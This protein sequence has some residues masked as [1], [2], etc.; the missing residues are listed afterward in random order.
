MA[1]KPYKSP[2]ID[3]VY[4]IDDAIA[5]KNSTNLRDIRMV[6]QLI[7]KATEQDI[8]RIFADWIIDENIKN[9]MNVNDLDV[10]KSD[11]QKYERGVDL[12]SLPELETN[13]Q[14]FALI[15]MFLNL[16]ENKFEKRELMNW[17]DLEKIKNIRKD[18]KIIKNESD[19]NKTFWRDFIPKLRNC[20]AHNRYI[21]INNGIYIRGRNK[22]R[23]EA[24]VSYDFFLKLVLFC[25]KY[26]RSPYATPIDTKNVDREKWF[27]AN[28]D[29]IEVYTIM[30]ESKQKNNEGELHK[31]KDVSKRSGIDFQMN[32]NKLTSGQIKFLSEYF[33]THEFN[34]ANLYFIKPFLVNNGIVNVKEIY[35]IF[36][37]YSVN[38][39]ILDSRENIIKLLHP[40]DVVIKDILE[41]LTKWNNIDEWQIWKADEDIYGEIKKQ[42]PNLGEDIQENILERILHYKKIFLERKE[43]ENYTESMVNY[44]VNYIK[45]L[46]L[47]KFYKNN[48]KLLK[49]IDTKKKDDPRW[50]EEHIRN[51]FA[52]HTYAIIP[53]FNKILLQDKFV[54][55]TP[56]WEK[57]YD[58]DE[59]YQ[60][61]V[62]RVDEDYLDIKVAA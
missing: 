32:T 49:L 24:K 33:K 55:G 5:M 53:W 46:Y 45:S 36:W 40:D 48:P 30:W 14:C 25:S 42:N 58:L 39:E 16:R 26:E 19:S 35:A 6:Q 61:A 15:D 31:I 22:K 13:T 28:K 34:R 41:M 11:I 10:I 12:E 37:H 57:M 44:R 23:F 8:A 52:H 60:D 62:S 17:D 51:A 59:L 21:M 29:N 20:I 4:T 50:E 3:K 27:D 7:S 47:S 1:K 38:E 43:Y 56:V 54:D 9:R 2:E 18:I